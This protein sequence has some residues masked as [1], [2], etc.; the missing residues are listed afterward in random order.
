MLVL[1]FAE[2]DFFYLVLVSK[3]L[4]IC[5]I[6]SVLNKDF[7]SQVVL[8]IFFSKRYAWTKISIREHIVQ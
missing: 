6:L 7:H 3:Y 1:H 4:A 2:A 5:V 8:L